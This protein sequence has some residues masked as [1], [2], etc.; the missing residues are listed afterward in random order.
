MRVPVETPASAHVCGFLKVRVLFTVTS[1]MQTRNVKSAVTANH[2]TG[3][4]EEPYL[5]VERY[6]RRLFPF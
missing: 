3:S 5:S 4:F 1:M 6:N 2:I